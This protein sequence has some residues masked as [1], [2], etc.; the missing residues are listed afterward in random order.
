LLLHWMHHLKFYK[1]FL[2]WKE[3]RMTSKNLKF[4]NA[5]WSYM[6]THIMPMTP[7]TWRRH[8]LLK[9]SLIWMIFVALD[10]PSKGLK[11][12]FWPSK[13]TKQWTKIY[14]SLSLSINMCIL[15]VTTK[16]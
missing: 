2:K 6:W 16:M 14:K 13:A 12:L 11:N 15:I 7:F 10:A 1:I 3:N 5:N 4:Q 8:I 9:P